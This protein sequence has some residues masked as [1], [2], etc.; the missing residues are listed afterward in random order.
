VNNVFKYDPATDV[1]RRVA[2]LPAPTGAPGVVALNGKIYAIG[3]RD[4]DRAT[5]NTT[6]IYDPAT[7]AWTLGAPL[8][9]ARD[10]LGIAVL[11]GRIHVFGGRTNA[12]VDNTTRHDIYN[13]ATDTWSDGA[14]LN[15]ARS[16]GVVFT[17]NGR[18]V[19]A[20]GECKD[21]DARTTFDD[22][23]VFDAAANR[24]TVLANMPIGRHAAAGVTVGDVGYVMGGANG[25]GTVRQ[26]KDI[27]AFRMQ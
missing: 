20:G 21:A 5:V 22:V 9:E 24:W 12:T 17:I 26:T 10:H 23:E 25:C 14:P 7:D 15:I 11:N 19:W 18:I 1:W 6:A 3:G 13:P 16:A 2:S 8:P 4:P 27:S